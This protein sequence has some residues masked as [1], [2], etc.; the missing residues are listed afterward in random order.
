MHLSTLQQVHEVISAWLGVAMLV[1]SI[2]ISIATFRKAYR[3]D[4][5]TIKKEEYT[6]EGQ[7]IENKKKKL[8]YTEELENDLDDIRRDVKELRDKS[9]ETDLVIARLKCQITNYQIWSSAL[10]NQL[11]E[12]QLVPIE[13]KDLKVRDCE[14]V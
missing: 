1:V 7:R 6:A 2:L 10:C 13:M 3:M 9:L 11:R 14:K 4:K 12:A 8:E 5:H